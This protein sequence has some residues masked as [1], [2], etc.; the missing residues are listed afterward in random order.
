MQAISSVNAITIL[1]TVTAA[2]HLFLGINGGLSLDP[3]DG[4]NVLFVLNGIGYFFL[5]IAVFWSPNFLKEQNPLLRRVF[6]SYVLLTIALYFI[7]NGAESFTSALGLFTKA[8]EVGL[9]A[10][11]WQSSRA[12][13]A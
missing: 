8:V 3:A 2:I 9:L 6:M 10:G 1:T 4:L 13:K 5:L 12:Q 11:I 7:I